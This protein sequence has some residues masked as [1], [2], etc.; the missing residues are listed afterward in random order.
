MV[1]FP[2]DESWYSTELMLLWA[3]SS[4]KYYRKNPP[5]LENL[6]DI[7]KSLNLQS[8][9]QILEN[10]WNEEKQKESPSFF[11]AFFKTIRKEFFLCTTLLLVVYM[12]YLVQIIAIYFIADYLSDDTS[13][14][15]Y[16]VILACIFIIASVFEAFFKIN[17]HFKSSLLLSK[18][19]SLIA[20]IIS[21]KSLKL[22]N[23]ALSDSNDKGK[24]INVMITDMEMLEL[25]FSTLSFL[26][27]PIILICY[28]IVLI[29]LFG[30]I[31]LIG[32]GVSIFHL[33]FIIWIS[34]KSSNHTL[35]ASKIGDERVKSIQNLIYGIK[36]I[37][38]YGWELPLLNVIKSLRSKEID[39]HRKSKL[40]YS[41]LSSFGLSGS[42]LAIFITASVQVACGYS[43]EAKK[44]FML[45]FFTFITHMLTA[46]LSIQG[47]MLIFSFLDNMNRIKD[48]LL[49]PEFE[50]YLDQEKT[51]FAIELENSSFGWKKD[52]KLENDKNYDE[53]TK[54]IEEDQ[55]VPVVLK[56]ISI[57][58]S[59]GELV[60]VIGQVG[61]GKSSLFLALLSELVQLSGHIKI[62]GSIA[63]S[64]EDPWI[65]SKTFKENIVLD[66]NFDPELYSLALSSCDLNEDLAILKNGD[67]TLIGE[68]GI[69]LSGGQRAR[70]CLAR[71]VYSNA[72]IMFLD[73]PLSAVDADVAN[74][75]F[76][77]CIQ[78]VLKNKTIILATNQIHFLQ[79]ADKILIFDKGSISFY[80]TFTEFQQFEGKN[81]SNISPKQTNEKN[82]EIEFSREGFIEKLENVHEE[83]IS[84]IQ[85][86]KA[87]WDYTYI[88]I[89]SVNMYILI[90]FLVLSI[91]YDISSIGSYYFLAYWSGES[92]QNQGKYYLIYAGILL[93]CYFFSAF[94]FL[95]IFNLY[96]NSSDKVHENSIRGLALTQSVYFDTH[97]SG[98]AIT[99][100]SKDIGVIDGPLQL[101]IVN[102]ITYFLSVLFFIIVTIIIIPIN[103]GAFFI[104]IILWWFLL[105]YLIKIIVKLR[106]IELISRDP[107]ISLLV[108]LINNLSSV[109]CFNYQQAFENECIENANLF[110]RA[111]LTLN[112]FLRFVQLYFQI[113]IISLLA[114]NAIIIVV[115]KSSFST[116]LGAFSIA[117]TAMIMCSISAIPRI[118]VD[119]NC[120]AAS[121]EKLAE[122]ANLH[123]EGIL[124]ESQEFIISH[125][126]IVFENIFMR[127]QP[128]LN[129]A[130][131]GLSFVINA[132]EKVGIVGRT[133]SGKSSIL[134][135][136]FRLVNPESGSVYID[137]QDYMKA[138]LHQLRSQMS[139]IPQTLALFIG[140]VKYNLDPL[141]QHTDEE[142]LLVLKEVELL[143]YVEGHEK[144]IDSLVLKEINFSAG[145]K[146][147]LCLARAVLRK[148]KIVMMDEAT[149]NVDNET[150]RIVQEVIKKKFDQCTMLIIAHRLR[151]IIDCD[152]IIVIDKGQC[153]E[154]GKP[155][156]IIKNENSLFRML[157]ES[158]GN[159]E[160]SFLISEIMKKS[161]KMHGDDN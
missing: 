111:S 129:L 19:K 67:S 57:K 38:L 131:N 13:S 113:I 68:N 45:S 125:G 116:E 150:D 160:S 138:G 48:I 102:F 11:K 132:K 33:P 62:S 159:E 97:N 100:F 1:F 69:T 124:I 73:D 108:Q 65:L 127:Y 145:Q 115:F 128:Q 22:S 59:K 137:G 31:G 60:I 126:K 121:V 103:A 25:M 84:D 151:T 95:P 144:G 104:S 49:L 56:D 10:F 53:N 114:L 153:G 81:L 85:W 7:P 148:N 112:V 87:L 30:P 107:I 76:F 55:E 43:L 149:S 44:I 18:T 122:L 143:D 88:G 134:Q 120:N 26:C 157:V 90:I 54:L 82:K 110:F 70:L 72:D 140:S 12:L 8:P 37:K 123:P 156:E 98:Q 74:H 93:A 71:C 99:R 6:F 106:D 2:Y 92:E 64:S 47:L 35:N 146:Q 66:K 9:M 142:I 32:I 39:F 52:K 133:G 3:F 50:S 58:V 20:L 91:C 41:G 152:K 105:K 29:W 24:I 79:H 118:I 94:R 158:T 147:L 136:L 61:S 78:K 135:V 46:Y 161:E 86:I 21:K 83:E 101:N 77:D 17:M 80:G 16:G 42:L 75:L 63:F 14:I 36:I 27:I 28:I 96:L 139:V 117:S 34:Q 4:I 130:L 40:L 155:V 119:L 109:R 141:C 89:K 51:D 154:I 5:N 23:I 15:W